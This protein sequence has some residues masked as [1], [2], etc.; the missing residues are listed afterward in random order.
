M[1]IKCQLVERT[2]KSGNIYVA[3]EITIGSY[4]KLVFL[5]PAELELIK[6]YTNT[7]QVGK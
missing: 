3:L 4:K 6:L 5:E 7:N 2:S 1:N